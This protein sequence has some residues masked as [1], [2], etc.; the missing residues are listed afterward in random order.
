MQH[1]GRSLPI[2]G[3]HQH[4][5]T[6][7]WL[8]LSTRQQLRPAASQSAKNTS[9]PAPSSSSLPAQLNPHCI[10]NCQACC[11]PM[12]HPS[13]SPALSI[14]QGLATLGSGGQVLA[15]VQAGRGGVLAVGLLKLAA[16]WLQHLLH[17]QGRQQHSRDWQGLRNDLQARKIFC[18]YATR[19]AAPC[20]QHDPEAADLQQSTLPSV[21]AWPSTLLAR[22]QQGPR[23]SGIS[24]SP[25]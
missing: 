22:H 9:F 20:W 17:S 25:P 7:A 6:A 10:Q 19:E 13:N 8:R 18:T 21:H 11:M 2:P 1:V 14:V 12:C 4:T 16:S 15:G 5:Q 3:S 24:F 23:S